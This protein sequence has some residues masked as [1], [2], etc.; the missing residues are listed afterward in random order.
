MGTHHETLVS[1]IKQQ[2]E[3]VKTTGFRQAVKKYFME[4]VMKGM[5]PPEDPEYDPSYT[6][7]DLFRD[8]TPR[9]PSVIP[10]A[11]KIDRE[12][13]ETGMTK[14]IV[15]EVEV[16]HPLD[17]GKLEAYGFFWGDLD[18]TDLPVDFELRVMDRHGNEKI[19]N[20]MSFYYAVLRKSR[21]E[22]T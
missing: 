3:G 22:P 7:E 2:H 6:P 12:Q 19:V 9:I 14:I 15:W 11:Y 18:A 10:D 5:P 13:D 20:P 17:I 1:I 16:G 4:F 21:Q 8:M